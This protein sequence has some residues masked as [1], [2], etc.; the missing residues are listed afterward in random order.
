[1]SEHAPHRLVMLA[2]VLA[3]LF[4]AFDF[5][6]PLGVAG[7]IPYIA[8]V[9]LGIWFPK[10]QHVYALAVIGSAFTI[11]GYFA[12][13]LGSVLWVVVTNRVLALAAI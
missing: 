7:G 12:S 13:S 5:L 6:L 11:I 4:L 2:A 1:M 9:L 10:K 3:I 8:L